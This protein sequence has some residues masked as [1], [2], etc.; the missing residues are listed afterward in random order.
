MTRLG[1]G[2]R[3]KMFLAAYSPDKTDKQIANEIG[4][5]PEYVRTTARRQGL[6]LKQSVRYTPAVTIYRET[7]ERIASG[8]SYYSQIARDALASGVWRTKQ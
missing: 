3:L 5:I 1:H 7:L 6:T 4:A 2:E 8:E